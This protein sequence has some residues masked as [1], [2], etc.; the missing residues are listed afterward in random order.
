M[1]ISIDRLG[2]IGLCCLCALAG[3]AHVHVFK[4][5]TFGVRMDLH[6]NVLVAFNRPDLVTPYYWCINCG[7]MGLLPMV[8]S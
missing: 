3:Y 4:S 8:H 2:A 5:R 6:G 7:P 1:A